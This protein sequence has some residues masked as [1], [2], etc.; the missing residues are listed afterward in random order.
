MRPE[1]RGCLLAVGWTYVVGLFLVLLLVAWE[2]I[3]SG[4]KYGLGWDS[5]GFLPLA[6]V[7]PLAIVALGGGHGSAPMS[8]W[9]RVILLPLVSVWNCARLVGNNLYLPTV[10]QATKRATDHR[11]ART[12]GEV[13]AYTV[14]ASVGLSTSCASCASSMYVRN[15]AKCASS[16]L[17]RRL[18]RAFCRARR[19]PRWR[20]TVC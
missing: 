16:S 20:G 18:D 3:S 11:P 10:D 13:R 4:L 9:A 6:I 5:L 2:A 17:G 12:E 14:Y 7:W 15:T 19:F 1:Q 8:F